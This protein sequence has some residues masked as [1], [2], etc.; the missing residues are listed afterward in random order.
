MKKDISETIRNEAKVQ[1]GGY[2]A[3][4]SGTLAARLF[5]DML[6]DKGVVKG[7]DGVISPGEGVIRA[8]KYF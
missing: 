8:E 4:L 1:K 7:G 2:D 3:M 5:I 6:L